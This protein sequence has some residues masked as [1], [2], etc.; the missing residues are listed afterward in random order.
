MISCNNVFTAYSAEI[1][2]GKEVLAKVRYSAKPAKATIKADG[3]RII[4][5]FEEPQRAATPGQSIVFYEGDH[6]IGGG[7][8]SE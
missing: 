1:Y 8:I 2:D 5:T 6:V 4:A 7:F 3:N